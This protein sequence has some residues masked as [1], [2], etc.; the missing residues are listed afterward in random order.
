[1]EVIASSG[2][3]VHIKGKL[4]DMNEDF[5]ERVVCTVQDEIN[6]EIQ[7]YAWNKVSRVVQP[8]DPRH[9]ADVD[10]VF[11]E[12]NCF[13]HSCEIVDDGEAVE[14]LDSGFRVC[15]Y[16][17]PKQLACCFTAGKGLKTTNKALRFSVSGEPVLVSLK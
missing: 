8:K 3:T 15:L 10:H 11:V 1:M 9:M 16:D 5:L 13:W 7:E 12:Q 2:E 6:G 4:L 17:S 14:L